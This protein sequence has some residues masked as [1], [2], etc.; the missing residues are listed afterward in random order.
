VLLLEAGGRKAA[1]TAV[2]HPT[3]ALQFKNGRLP[4]HVLIYHHASTLKTT[5]LSEAADAFRLL[6]RLYPEAAGTVGGIGATHKKTPY[7]L[8]VREG[9]PTYYHRLLLRAAP[10]LDP[11][12]LRRLNW[13]ERRM[14]MFVAFAGVAKTRLLLV[15]LRMANMN[16]LEHVV[17]YL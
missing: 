14:A 2:V 9:L 12:E 16:L 5:P 11:A 3:N 15:K 1:S 13:A 6:L 17:S 10:D 8:A 4:L 7:Q